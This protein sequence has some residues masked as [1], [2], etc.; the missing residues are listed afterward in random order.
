MTF[1]LEYLV[2]VFF[3][4]IK[5]SVFI[6]KI[7]FLNSKLTG[8]L[9]GWQFAGQYDDL[10]AGRPDAQLRKLLHLLLLPGH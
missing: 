2:T 10:A 8:R 1:L 4:V 3:L 6:K 9:S 7:S 5:T